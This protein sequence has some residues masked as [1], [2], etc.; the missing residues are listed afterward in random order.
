MKLMSKHNRPKYSDS[1]E[2]DGYQNRF[3]DVKRRAQTLYK[4]KGPMKRI[5]HIWVGALRSN[6][7]GRA[8]VQSLKASDWGGTGFLLLSKY[9]AYNGIY[10]DLQRPCRESLTDT[11]FIQSFAIC[12]LLTEGFSTSTKMWKYNVKLMIN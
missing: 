2:I 1:C 7:I 3:F 8:R 12:K 10:D 9:A 11:L 5:C 6:A 4:K